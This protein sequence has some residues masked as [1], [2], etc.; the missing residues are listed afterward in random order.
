MVVVQLSI[1]LLLKLVARSGLSAKI[2]LVS[3]SLRHRLFTRN[4]SDTS[5]TAPLWTENANATS[6]F[7]MEALIEDMQSISANLSSM[8]RTPPMALPY[9]GDEALY[10]YMLGGN[11]SAPRTEYAPLAGSTVPNGTVADVIDIHRRRS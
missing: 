9:C 5:S 2:A 10:G 7:N 11:G 1:S 3:R 4:S 6:G 8:R